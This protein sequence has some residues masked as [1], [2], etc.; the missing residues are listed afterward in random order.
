[1]IEKPDNRERNRITRR[2]YIRMLVGAMT[3]A[4][5]LFTAA[6]LRLK[7]LGYT[8]ENP[9]CGPPSMLI[10]L[11]GAWLGM[12]LGAG[13]GMFSVVFRTKENTQPVAGATGGPVA[14]P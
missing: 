13:A 7:H 1:M 3:G 8:G 5:L 11:C 2:F 6:W 9:F 14:Q 4:V 12:V 10:C